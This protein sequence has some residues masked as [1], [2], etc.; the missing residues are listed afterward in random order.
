MKVLVVGSGGR[1]HALAWKL[2]SDRAATKV[3][4]APGSEAMAEVAERVSIEAL[5]IRGLADFAQREG[6]G[7]TVVGPEAPLAAGIVDEFRARGLRIFGP[8]SEGARLEASKAFAKRLLTKAGIPT[9]AYAEFDA[10]QLHEA[11]RFARELGFPVV[12]KADGLAAG[13]G[14]VICASEKESDDAIADMLVAGSF[15]EAGRRVVVEEFME[16]E[17]ASF[18]AITDGRTALPLVTSQDHKTVLDGDRGP[19]TGG[20]GAYSPAPV[21]T[22]AMH[23]LIMATVIEPTVT[24]LREAGID[25]RG[26]LYAGIMVTPRGPRVLEYNVRFGD[27]EC[28]A[29]LMRLRSSLVELLLAAIDGR[30]DRIELQW[31]PGTSACIVM[32]AE[33]YPGKVR[34]GDAIE[35]IENARRVPAVQVFHAGTRCDSQGRFVT[36]G[37]RV[38]GVCATGATAV[39]A[40]ARAYE[41]AGKIHWTGAHYRRDIAWRALARE[42]QQNKGAS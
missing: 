39:E 21:I 2:A 23:E 20:M 22:P 33:G 4:V 32:A 30:L 6:I 3:F 18:M 27:P 10:S 41:A 1:E 17:E 12:V 7:L 11:Q 14:V 34:A 37:G 38:L 28:Q 9:A 35:G 31:E 16:G 25:Y 19:N 8:D 26:V 24:A 40:T 13:K 5:D 15:G 42:R 36:A 29:I